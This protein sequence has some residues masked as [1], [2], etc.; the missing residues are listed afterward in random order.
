MYERWIY[1]VAAGKACEVSLLFSKTINGIKG[2]SLD[3]AKHCILPVA[4][5]RFKQT[6]QGEKT[7]FVVVL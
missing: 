2:K 7:M 3:T 1:D 6:L 5:S 4:M